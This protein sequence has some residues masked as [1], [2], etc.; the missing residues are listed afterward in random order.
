M[1][2]EKIEATVAANYYFGAPVTEATVKYKVLRSDYSQR[3]YP[4]APWDWCFGPGYWWFGYDYPWY[5]GWDQWVGC[6]R[7][8]PWWIWEQPSPPPEVVAEAEFPVGPDGTI[9]IEIYTAVAK[10]LHG[11]TDHGTPL[12]LRRDAFGEPLRRGYQSSAVRVFTSIA[13]TI[14]GD[15]VAEVSQTLDDHP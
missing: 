15:V 14:G 6:A 13:A 7:P 3:W 12:P 1:L 2:G 11:D 8:G 4:L 10:A 5:P 9:S